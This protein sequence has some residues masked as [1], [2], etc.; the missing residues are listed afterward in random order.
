MYR[1]DVDI[2]PDKEIQLFTHVNNTDTSFAHVHRKIPR[3]TVSPS[4]YKDAA[5]CKMKCL[6]DPNLKRYK[7]T[8][9]QT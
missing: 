5:A 2:D 3:S 4:S 9:R 1:Y 6:T 7:C 8:L